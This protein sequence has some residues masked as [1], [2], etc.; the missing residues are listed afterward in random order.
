MLNIRNLELVDT[1]K[2]SRGVGHFTFYND[3]LITTNH[4]STIKTF[5]NI[6]NPRNNRYI[7][8]L[9]FGDIVYDGITMQ[10]HTTHIINNNLYFM[11]NTDSDS[12]LYE[13]NLDSISITRKITLSN[14]YCLMGGLV[15]DTITTTLLHL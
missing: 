7:T 11:F 8:S 1:F 3:M 15:S 4:Y 14:H 2:A 13:V 10:S 9:S 12:I 6:S 5:H